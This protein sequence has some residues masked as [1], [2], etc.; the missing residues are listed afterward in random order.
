MTWFHS[1][2]HSYIYLKNIDMNINIM[3]CCLGYHIRMC[4]SEA[5]KT[6]FAIDEFNSLS[7]GCFWSLQRVHDLPLIDLLLHVSS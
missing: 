1:E 2:D 4:R 7:G 3:Q 6:N 5:R